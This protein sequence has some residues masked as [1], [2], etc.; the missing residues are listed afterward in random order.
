MWPARNSASVIGRL[1]LEAHSVLSTAFAQ[2][3]WR[4]VGQFLYTL[5]HTAETG[6]GSAQTCPVIPASAD[7][8]HQLP[9][10]LWERTQRAGCFSCG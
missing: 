6:R 2:D 4:H 10:S 3:T 5:H 7:D 1:A 8:A 9:A